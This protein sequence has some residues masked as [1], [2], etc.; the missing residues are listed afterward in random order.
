MQTFV[1]NS[2]PTVGTKVVLKPES[3]S[4][5]SIDKRNTHKLIQLKPLMQRSDAAGGSILK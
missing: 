3:Q 5:T 1:I 2:T 4:L